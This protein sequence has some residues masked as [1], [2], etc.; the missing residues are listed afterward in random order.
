[1]FFSA[2]YLLKCGFYGQNM[3]KI[4]HISVYNFYQIAVTSKVSNPKFV[5]FSLEIS[6]YT[7]FRQNFT[8]N[9]P[10]SKFK[11]QRR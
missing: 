9:P 3:H 4:G 8:K 11:N 10:K 2:Q 7:Q 1:M 5:I 6:T